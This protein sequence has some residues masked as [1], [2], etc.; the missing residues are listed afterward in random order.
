MKDREGFI[1]ESR[2]EADLSLIKKYLTMLDEVSLN[3]DEKNRR[4]L[5][6]NLE[7]LMYTCD[8][9]DLDSNIA[10]KIR[11]KDGLS[12]DQLGEKLGC[13]KQTLS[14]Y[15]NGRI[16]DIRKIENGH[17]GKARKYLEYLRDRGGYNPYNL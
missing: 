1:S 8:R 5:I 6:K 11:R 15:E 10:R 7:N 3:L 14:F 17:S 12:L 16:P 13:S 4:R 2:K 9:S